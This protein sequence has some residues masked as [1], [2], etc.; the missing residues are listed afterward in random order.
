[1]SYFLQFVFYEERRVVIQQWNADKASEQRRNESKVVIWIISRLR[2]TW[3][4][5][6]SY[7]KSSFGVGGSLKSCCLQ[8]SLISYT[9]ALC[10]Y[11]SCEY[12]IVIWFIS[13]V[14]F[15]IRF[16]LCVFILVLHKSISLEFID[17][18]SYFYNFSVKVLRY[19]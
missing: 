18:T 8:I 13:V 7:L 14:Y 11:Q 4:D 12:W 19:F 3:V 16:L 5:I 2:S 6:F 10:M 9:N 1:M 17:L 15:R